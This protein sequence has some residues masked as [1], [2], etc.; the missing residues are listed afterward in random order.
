MP[1][2]RIGAA[3]ANGQRGVGDDQVGEFWH[4]VTLNS[5]LLGDFQSQILHIAIERRWLVPHDY[6]INA[7]L[8]WFDEDKRCC[9]ETSEQEVAYCS[10]T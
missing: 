1:T 3:V 10:S 9:I 2:L 4:Q 8:E 6:K 5:S 7:W